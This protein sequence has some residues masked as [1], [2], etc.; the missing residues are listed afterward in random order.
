ML[1]KEDFKSYEPLWKIG[2]LIFKENNKIGFN[3]KFFCLNEL[4]KNKDKYTE[5][6]TN[7]LIGMVQEVREI[8]KQMNPSDIHCKKKE[9]ETYISAYFATLEKQRTSGVNTQELGEKYKLFSYLVEPLEQFNSLN[10]KARK[11]R[12]KINIYIHILLTIEICCIN[13]SQEMIEN[14][15]NNSNKNGHDNNK[16]NIKSIKPNKT[17]VGTL[18]L[19]NN[20]NYNHIQESNDT[21]NMMTMNNHFTNPYINT[22]ENKFTKE[23]ATEIN[24]QK[25]YVNITTPTPMEE[26][27]NSHQNKSQE[28]PDFSSESVTLD[29][30]QNS[31]KQFY[32]NKDVFN[33]CLSSPI[34]KQSDFLKKNNLNTI[35]ELKRKNIA[36]AIQLMKNSI[37]T[38]KTLNTL[39]KKKVITCI[40]LK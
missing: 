15:T 8:Q 33:E 38:L 35:N 34:I 3:I 39:H 26:K 23:F 1:C 37:N 24:T 7:T 25:K 29:R 13:T 32:V 16:S 11:I 22:H 4:I 14:N 36:I 18:Q 27:S 12:K 20:N 9:Y 10:D 40:D 5:D 2:D 30:H 6:Q 21:K 28:F 31:S 17:E 19:N